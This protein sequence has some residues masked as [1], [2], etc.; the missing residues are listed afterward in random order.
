ML[1]AAGAQEG[2]QPSG[3]AANLVGQAVVKPWDPV[4]GVAACVDCAL[5]H[6]LHKIANTAHDDGGIR[7]VC[8]ALPNCA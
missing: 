2:R 8:L 1:P 6:E 5:L 3:G 7:P 4:G